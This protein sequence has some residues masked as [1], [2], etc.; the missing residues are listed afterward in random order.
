MICCQLQ[1]SVSISSFSWRS[2]SSQPGASGSKG[3]ALSLITGHP[4]LTT[5]RATS[6]MNAFYRLI[7]SVKLSRH[8]SQNGSIQGF[9]QLYLYST[10]SVFSFY[11]FLQLYHSFYSCSVS[12]PLLLFLLIINLQQGP[13]L[14]CVSLKKRIAASHNNSCQLTA[15][16]ELH[17]LQLVHMIRHYMNLIF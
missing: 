7:G 2:L 8:L 13:P 5:G 10:Q 16:F 17:V 11:S 15:G 4:Q 1:K 3:M 6:L 14:L 12:I 9:S